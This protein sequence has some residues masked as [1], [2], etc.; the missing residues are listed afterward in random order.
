MRRA[1]G[2]FDGGRVCALVTLALLSAACETLNSETLVKDALSE[3]LRKETTLDSVLPSGCPTLTMSLPEGK[4]RVIVS[5]REPSQDEHGIALTTLAFTTIYLT[6]P[7]SK[8]TAFRIW[9]NDA[10]GG[11]QV[12]V[13]DIPV[14]DR[15]VGVCVTATNWGRK[16][17]SP[18]TATPA[19][20]AAA[21]R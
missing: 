10:R 20:G 16:E 14:S 18:G 13:N 3:E 2:I 1:C 5:Y 11:A 15:E 21:S 4:Q 19:S 8:T 17:S 9:T 7:Q 6:G 12:T